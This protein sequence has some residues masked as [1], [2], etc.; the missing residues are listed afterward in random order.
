MK[1]SSSVTAAYSQI[2]LDLGV[3]ISRNSLYAAIAF[4]VSGTGFIGIH[5]LARYVFFGPPSPQILYLGISI[6]LLALLQAPVLLLGRR[7]RGIAASLLSSLFISIFAIWLVLIWGGITLAVALVVVFTHARILTRSISKGYLLALFFTK[8]VGIAGIVIVD[9]FPVLSI[10]R[11]QTNTPSAIASLA[12]LSATV[13]ILLTI[14]FIS[15]NRRFK[16]L[17]SQFLLTS[18][19][20]VTIPTIFAAVLASLGGYVNIETQALDTLETISNLKVDQLNNLITSFENDI[21]LIQ[22]DPVFKTNVTSALTPGEIP[23]SSIEMLAETIRPRLQ[24]IQNTREI[25]FEEIMVLDSKGNSLIS[26][27]KA[28]EGS[29]YQSDLFFS[30]G[31]LTPYIGFADESTYGI[32]NLFISAPI[33]GGDN[34]TQYGVLV[35][36]ANGRLIKDIVEHT[37]GYED[38]ETYLLDTNLHPITKLRTPV[39]TVRTQASVSASIN[40]TS[41][42][43]GIYKNYNGDTVLGYYRLFPSLDALFITELPRSIVLEKSLGI[44][45]ASSSLAIIVII[46]AISIGAITANL[47]VQPITSLVKTTQDFAN[48]K[49]GTRIDLNR[50]DEIG[51][52]GNTFNHMA[53]K[54]QD[55]IGQLEQRGE[56]RTRKLQEQSQRLHIAAEVAKETAMIS[57]PV[58]LLKDA[59]GRIQER[60]GF[61]HVCIFLLDDAREYAI[62]S[63]STSD[64]GI[65]TTGEGDKIRISDPDIVAR[66]AATGDPQ[67]SFDTHKDSSNLLNP[68]FPKT[69]SE[70]A[71]PIRVENSTIGVLDIQSSDPQAF[72]EEDMAIMSIITDQ[73]GITLERVRLIQRAEENL[74]E[75][76]EA[77]ARRSREG[78]NTLSESGTL[79]NKGYRFDNI[80]VRPINTTP[81]LGTKAIETGNIISQKG[82][83]SNKLEQDLVAI[84]IKLRGQAIGV[85]TFRLKGGYNQSTINTLEQVVER[86]AGSLEGA[87]IFE[88]ARSRAEREQKISRVISAIS[89][90][91][92]F[93]AIMRTTVEEI[94][95]SLG[96][97]EVSIQLT[98]YLE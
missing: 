59:V 16:S 78:W 65:Q 44:F 76:E 74:D 42:N 32:S 22:S 67:I 56:E 39:K 84:P 40:N 38:A 30:Q 41:G 2:D 20:I 4:G 45:A 14:A 13:L 6:I 79:Q 60:F 11:L 82:D 88:E 10:V 27:N 7:G 51:N 1:E 77:Y 5:F 52:L 55:I 80:R 63:A 97:S 46:L 9:R 64:V 37:P 86:L 57:D 3:E 35:I 90:A 98:E 36:R 24:E 31:Y 68:R 8:V 70:M 95:R 33:Y 26:T 75:L 71:L 83:K 69:Q 92:D 66:A 25:P 19:I 47:T 81:E 89:S 87:R 28:N 18:V 15:G 43:R 85:V 72:S 48:G 91:T 21:S 50:N 49:F 96:D 12:F 61:Y 58:I 54:L 17:K 62:L 73:L 94:G 93:D 53:G 29:T 23:S 34:K